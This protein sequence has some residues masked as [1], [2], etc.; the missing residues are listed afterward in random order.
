M[1]QGAKSNVNNGENCRPALQRAGHSRQPRLP[2]NPI[3]RSRQSRCGQRQ[4]LQYRGGVPRHVAVV[5]PATR[6]EP[7]GADDPARLLGR[8]RDIA[9]RFVPPCDCAAPT[10]EL[11]LPTGGM[12]VVPDREGAKRIYLSRAA[13]QPLY[14]GLRQPVL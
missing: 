6:V 9:L 4:L 11:D 13:Q 14:F 3:Q 12:S 5:Q 1:A 2:P 10:I 7:I 8:M